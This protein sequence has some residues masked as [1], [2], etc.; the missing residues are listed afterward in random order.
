MRIRTSIIPAQRIEHH[1]LLIRGQKVILDS[2]LARLYGVTTKRLNEQIKRNKDRFP[3]DFMFQLSPEEKKHV[4]A[5]CDHLY[6]L[7]YSPNLPYAFT[8]HGVIMAANVLNSDR[9]I[10]VSIYVVR[11]FTNL[12][13]MLTT[14]KELA[15]K[16]AQLEQKLQT[17]DDQIMTIFDAI[18]QLMEPAIE[19]PR[20]R[21]GYLTEVEG[22]KR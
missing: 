8:E 19:P 10:Q 1:I 14:H 9:A 15:R 6:K 18:R 13:S 5:N 12:R 22:R 11:A 4:V 2:D 16:L 20:K 17:H 7:R 3:D 21:I